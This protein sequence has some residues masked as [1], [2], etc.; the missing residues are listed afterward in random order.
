MTNE[1]LYVLDTNK[2]QYISRSTFC[3]KATLCIVCVIT[4]SQ[5]D[6]SHDKQSFQEFTCNHINKYTAQKQPIQTTNNISC[7]VGDGEG[8]S[9]FFLKCKPVHLYLFIYLLINIL[10]GCPHNKMLVSQGVLRD[11][12]YMNII[13]MFLV[14]FSMKMLQIRWILQLEV[15]LMMIKLCLKWNHQVPYRFNVCVY[16]R[17]TY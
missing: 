11:K 17:V 1:Y 6:L 3:N 2:Q 16:N 5:S 12:K 4:I 7:Y 8:E 10:A 9:G 15:H 14:L 13:C